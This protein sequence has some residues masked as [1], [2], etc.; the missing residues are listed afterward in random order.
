MK[1]WSAA[2]AAPAAAI[3]HLG[4]G[5]NVGDRL[6]HLQRA[7]L[8]LALHPELEIVSVSELYETEYVGPGQQ[9]PYLNA[10]A[11]ISTALAPRVLL[12]VLQAIEA[13]QGRPSGGHLQPRTLDLDILL[14]GDLTS[15][16][17]CLTLPHP[18][19]RERAFMLAPLRDIAPDLRLPESQETVAAACAKIAACDGPWVRRCAADGRWLRPRA[20]REDEWRAALA[21]HCR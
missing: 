8:A 3:V 12:A 16:D 9:D 1:A 6:G 19:L 17:P 10:C 15:A 5:S 4:L 20:G 7:L 18:R 2:A 13:R 11:A 21:V 14:F